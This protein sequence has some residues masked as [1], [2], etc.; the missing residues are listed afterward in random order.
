[1]PI[2]IFGIIATTRWSTRLDYL[3]RVVWL[4]RIRIQFRTHT[5]LMRSRGSA[6]DTMY[7]PSAQV[8]REMTG[9]I[10]GLWIDRCGRKRRE[11]SLVLKCPT[12]VAKAIY[13]GACLHLLVADVASQTP[14]VRCVGLRVQDQDKHPMVGFAGYRTRDEQRLLLRA[15]RRKVLPLHVFDEL[16]RC[17]GSCT[18]QLDLQGCERLL[19]HLVASPKPYAGRF[20][21]VVQSAGDRFIELLDS[22]TRGDVHPNV[23]SV[24]CILSDWRL[25]S[26][27]GI[28]SGD[29][30]LDR[31]EGSGLEQMAHQLVE[32][33]F[34]DKAFRS[35]NVQD[36]ARLRELCDANS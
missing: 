6:G 8:R 16:E 23:M 28:G 31:N 32:S 20:G 24:Q 1:M 27:V 34:G 11:L 15:L 36:R 13:R 21:P 4:G 30:R 29:F 5:G 22:M 9:A 25:T 2:L 18:L 10:I 7:V 14:P 19:S 12:H 17:V 3:W 26:I 35:P 33:L